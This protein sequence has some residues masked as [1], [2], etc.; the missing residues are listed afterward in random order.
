MTRILKPLLFVLLFALS[1]PVAA[2]LDDAGS[3]ELK[4]RMCHAV[5][6]EA[7]L[8]AAAVGRL[9]FA[10]GGRP[11]DFHERWLWL[12]ADR[13][14]VPTF[15]SDWRLV[16]DQTRFASMRAIIVYDDGAIV[17]HRFRS[18]AARGHW[19]VGGF[20]RFD[21]DAR[22]TPVSEIYL[23]VERLVNLDTMRKVR[24]VA[25]PAFIRTQILWV[26]IAS[27]FAGVVGASLAYTS[28]LYAGLRHAF[29]RQYAFWCLAVLAYGLSWSNLAYYAVPGLAGSWGVRLN[30][31]TA[32]FATLFASL[33]MVA[34]LEPFALPRRLRALLV[35][36]GWASL[37]AAILASF[38]QLGADYAYVL[39]RTLNGLVA[40]GVVLMLACIGVA[41]RRGSRSIRFYALAWSPALAAFVLRMLR[42]FHVVPH[43][44][45]I[46]MCLFGATMIETMLLSAAISDRFRK[47]EG[48]RNK[49]RAERAA[50]S[51]LAETD[52]LTGLYNRRGF[53]ARVEAL[54]A[55]RSSAMGLI[56]IDVDHFK[57]INDRFGHDAGDQV[58]AEIGRVLGRLTAPRLAAGRLGG[59]EF[60][61][62]AAL[63]PDE[64]A[65]LGERARHEIGA[66][67]FDFGG[68]TAVTISAGV[69]YTRRPLPFVDLYRTADLALYA[70][71][72]EGRDR[73]VASEDGSARRAA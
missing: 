38:D 22:A 27:A 71:K 45:W 1:G 2:H 8:S 18:G 29:L 54:V 34:F 51:H 55:S 63:A 68:G 47:L 64:L 17:E 20:L 60:G 6:D 67:R 43:A 41:Y 36:T 14:D 35:A 53:V 59:E 23:G 44:D 66:L 42:N 15:K 26:A 4:P 39:D 25:E 9:P 48:E 24:A 21:V 72:S 61:L 13:A 46:D 62:A 65:A 56:L 57:S 3:I 33:F 58:L 52:D 5:A 19:A 32:G 30:L 10:C 37:V 28:F 12:R 16:V 40:F 73:V 69:A 49:A 7:A 70:A 11:R 50:L 31:W